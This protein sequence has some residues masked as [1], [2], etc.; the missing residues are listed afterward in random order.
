MVLLLGAGVIH[1]VLLVVWWHASVPPPRVACPPRAF[2]VR[3]GAASRQKPSF[4]QPL[5]YLAQGCPRMEESRLP[6]ASLDALV[7]AIGDLSIRVRAWR[8]A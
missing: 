2:F 1:C 5:A 4:R 8:L 7:E 3:P 6:D